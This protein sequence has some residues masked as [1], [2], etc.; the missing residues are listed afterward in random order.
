MRIRF[1][2][3]AGVIAALAFSVSAVAAPTPFKITGGGQTFATADYEDGIQGPGDTI[4]FQA[5]IPAQGT[6]EDSTGQVNIIDRTPGEGGKGDHF[7]GR[8]E[9]SFLQSDPLTG[10]GYAELRGV[11]IKDDVERN[12]L[13]RIQDNGQGSAAEA[14]LVEFELGTGDIPQCEDSRDDQG[15]EGPQMTLARG[16]AKIHKQNP[17][18]SK[19]SKKSSTSTSST[20][21]ATKSTSLTSAL[22]LR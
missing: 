4:T 15:D 7:R 3:V 18:T 19:S 11:G 14:D 16:N 12:F 10:G 20:S 13:I 2:V 5:F 8:V 9:C 21:T 6:S 17:S 1:G 22:S